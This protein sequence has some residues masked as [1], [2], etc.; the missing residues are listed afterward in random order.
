MKG[1]ET[2]K[3]WELS[4]GREEEGMPP[5]PH[6]GDSGTQMT[7]N[8]QEP[9]GG[10]YLDSRWGLLSSASLEHCLTPEE[11]FGFELAHA[12]EIHCRELWGCL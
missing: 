4:S 2:I 8:D 10:G 11:W 1:L 7:T 9:V 5:S 6:Y 12:A 3:N